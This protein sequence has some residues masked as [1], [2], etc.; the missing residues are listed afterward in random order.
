MKDLPHKIDIP[1]LTE[2]ASDLEIET[3]WKQLCKVQRD[4]KGGQIDLSQISKIFY[5]KWKL[6]RKE[7]YYEVDPCFELKSG[8]EENI[9]E[10]KSRKARKVLSA[11]KE[12]L[13]REQAFL[14]EVERWRSK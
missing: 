12:N 6:I 5:D 13:I 9:I 8:D 14:G 1:F 2:Q 7:M 10:E 4:L 11:G 3:A